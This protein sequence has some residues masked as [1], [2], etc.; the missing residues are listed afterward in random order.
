MSRIK[1]NHVFAGLL[2][3]S[4]VSAFV[5]PKKTSAVRANV[6]SVFYPV[7]KPSRMIASALRG[8]FDRPADKRAEKDVVAENHRLRATVANLMGQI[9]E[10]RKIVSE[11]AEFGDI[12]NFCTPVPVMGSD[13]A[14]RDSL[15]VLGT[16]D[17]NLFGQPVLYIGGLAGT[18]ERAG[19][20]GAQVR[21]VTDRSFSASASIGSFATD[22]YGEEKFRAAEGLPS[23]LVEGTGRGGMIIKNIEYEDA[24]KH[25]REGASVV[26]DDKDFPP[27]LARQTLGRVVS[28]KK[29]P[30]APLMADIEV[31]PEWN[32]MALR[33]VMVF[34]PGSG[35]KGQHASTN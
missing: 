1:F 4:L 20:S 34:Q 23:A 17:V 24:V 14:G 19:V 27:I 26:L 10:L 18:I 29:R 31:R 3:L 11:R 5:F 35:G 16:F 33:E 13:P 25:V 8:P 9:D 15:S 21:L 30:E 12:G 7:A 28:V 32:L 6:Q 22:V 2:L